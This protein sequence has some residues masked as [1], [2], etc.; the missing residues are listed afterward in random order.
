MGGPL[1]A[2]HVRTLD[3]HVQQPFHGPGYMWL[4]ADSTH[5]RQ[6]WPS[7]GYT[8]PMAVVIHVWQRRQGAGY[9]FF[10]SVWAHVLGASN[11]ASK[12]YDLHRDA[13]PCGATGPS[14]LS[15]SSHPV[16]GASAR[17][18]L[19]SALSSSPLLVRP[20]VR[21]AIGCGAQHV[22]HSL[23]KPTQLTSVSWGVS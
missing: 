18:P 10:L 2:E 19:E 23:P 8:Y 12:H 20:G 11:G 1:G 17:A 21:W 14:S 4:Q 9:T 13:R 5:V 3:I 7:V 16:C 22:I 6:S 15:S